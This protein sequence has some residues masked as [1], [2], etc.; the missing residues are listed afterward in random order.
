MKGYFVWAPLEE[1]CIGPSS[2][3]EKK[4]KNQVKVFQKFFDTE[5]VLLPP[6][7]KKRIKKLTCRLPLFPID[8]RWIYHREYDDADFLY[9]RQVRHDRSFV[10][11]LKQIKSSNPGTKIL[12]EI[13]TYPYEQE[14]KVTVKNCHITAKDRINRRLLHNYV[15]RVVTF[16]HQESILGI[17]TLRVINGFD[18]SSVPINT[19]QLDSETLHLVEVSTTAFWHGYDRIISG[20]GEY[21]RTGGTRNIVFHMVGLVLPEHQKMVEVNGLQQHVVFHG[22]QSGDALNKIY[23]QCH[24]GVDVLGGHRKDYPISSSLKSREY[25]AHGLPILTASPV[26]YLGKSNHYQMLV[27]YDDSPVDIEAVISFA[28]VCYSGKPL[29]TVRDEIRSFAISQCDMNKTML[30][31]ISY[32]QG[33]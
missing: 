26:D 24:I 33:G 16:Y 22:F 13:P 28:D 29:Q 10:N 1:G 25:A 14:Q 2:G 11:Y 12:Y 8:R 7:Q 6:V 23:E 17:P 4:I 27:P 31:I 15:D 9:F 3:V 20:L 19:Q 30:P 32:I 21:Y 5:F 18:F